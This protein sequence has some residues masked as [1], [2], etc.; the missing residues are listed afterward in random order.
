MTKENKHTFSSIS[1]FTSRIRHRT[2]RVIAEEGVQCPQ[3]VAGKLVQGAVAVL[4]HLHHST[5]NVMSLPEW[6]A[7]ADLSTPNFLDKKEV[8]KHG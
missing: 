4:S 3:V 2:Y 1:I 5:R 8:T 7:L 6:N